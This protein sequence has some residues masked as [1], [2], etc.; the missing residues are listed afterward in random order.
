MQAIEAA[1]GLVFQ[2]NVL[3][4]IGGAAMFG[5]F[6]GAIPGLTA[7]MAIALLVPV[8]FFMDPVPAVGAMISCSA[9][10]IFAGDIPGTL[11]RIPG[12]PAS[13]AYTSEAY[14]M[15][16]KGEGEIALGANLLFSALGGLFGT[17]VLIVAAPSLAELALKFSSFEYFWLALLGLTCAVFIGAD[18]AVKGLVSLFLGLLIS[19]IGLNNPAGVPRFTFDNVDLTGG[20]DFIPAMIG[21]FAVSEVLRCMVHGA[22]DLPLPQTSVGNLFAGWGRMFVTYWRQQIRGNVMGTAIG[23]LPGAGADIAAWVS[24]ATSRKFS[25]TPEK[26]GTGHVEGIIESTS[27]NNAALAGAWVPA[28]VFGIPGDSITAVVIGVLYVKGLNPGPTIF[29]NSPEIIYAVFLI[30]ILANIAMIPLGWAAIKGAKQI[31][32]APRNILMPLILAFCIVGAFATNNSAF[33]VVIMLVFGV[34]GFLMEENDIPIA[35]CILGI[36]LGPL[37]EENFVTSMIKAD[38]DFLAFFER[39]IAATAG[40]ATLLIWFLPPLLRLR[41]RR[42]TNGPAAIG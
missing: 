34:I 19:T 32:R 23:A 37:L 35:P 14:A 6:V 1:F 12:T 31:L 16:K 25:K 39:P 4:V 22:K 5:L 17:L 8:T 41:R 10:A 30:F 18:S 15:T 42:A 29:L 26:F 9:M 2:W 3:L 24:Y 36:V 28:L 13:A 7:T 38:G 11:L 21:L 20:I 40:V 33:G 27:A